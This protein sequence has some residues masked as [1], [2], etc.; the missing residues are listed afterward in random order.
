MK[1][2]RIAYPSRPA[3]SRIFGAAQA[4][5]E[6]SPLARWQSVSSGF[7]VITQHKPLMPQA[8]L[9]RC[10]RATHAWVGRRQKADHRNEQQARIERG[11]AVVLHERVLHRIKAVLAHIVVDGRADALPMLQG[12]LQ[13]KLLR[14]A[15][16]AKVVVDTTGDADLIARS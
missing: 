9:D 1:S 3:A 14:H 2:G 5:P 10:E 11:C 6:K 8:A 13:V 16:L 15:V 12:R 7:G 4:R